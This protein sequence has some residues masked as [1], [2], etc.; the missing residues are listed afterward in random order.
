M[1]EDYTILKNVE[2]SFEEKKSIFICNIK[3][4]SNEKEAMEFISEIKEKY[5]DARH[6]VFSYITNNKI[7]MRYSDD[8][9]P[10][11]TAGPP[12]LEV[13]KREG[14]NDVVVVVTRY[15]GGILLGA[16]G[17][18]R[19]YTSSC[20]QGVDAAIKVKRLKGIRF[21]ITCDYE[22]YGKINNYIQGLNV[23][24]K[25]VTFLENVCIDIV[26]L[27]KDIN[28]IKNNLV[29]MMNGKN[30]ISNEEE[31]QCFVDENEG[32]MEV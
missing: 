23:I 5:K 30:I 7:S 10:Q 13:L 1:N 25:D 22:M 11:G 12:I 24:V 14:L 4:I 32:L 15:F 17:L 3:R 27:E 2:V 26:A 8:G 18:I 16:G 29:E 9:E 28:T 31:I 21:N 19:A 20:K 6:N